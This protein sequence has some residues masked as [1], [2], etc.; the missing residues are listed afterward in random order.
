[1]NKLY[2]NRYYIAIY[3]KITA[4][5]KITCKYNKNAKNAHLIALNVN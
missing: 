4:L 3:V 1:M 2:L 5:N